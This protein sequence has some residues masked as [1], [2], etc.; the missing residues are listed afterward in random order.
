MPDVLLVPI[1]ILGF[2]IFFP[3]L[4]CGVV[5]LIAYIGGWRTLAEVYPA[6][7]SDTAEWKHMTTGFLGRGIFSIGQYKSVLSVGKDGRFIHLKPMA[8][9]SMFHPQISIPVLDIAREGHGDGF[10]STARLS[11]AKSKVELRISGKLAN[12]L[13]G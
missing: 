6:Q 3:L 1:I 5:G 12:W 4:W 10:L 2:L 13:L 9:F 7:P 11:F 8:L